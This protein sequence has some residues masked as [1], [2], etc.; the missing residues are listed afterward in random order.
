MEQLSRNPDGPNKVFEDRVINEKIHMDAEKMREISRNAVE[1]NLKNIGVFCL[2]AK[3]DDILMWS[4]YTDGH[5]GFCLAFEKDFYVKKPKKVSYKRKYP[6]IAFTEKKRKEW[7]RKLLL[8]KSKRWKYEE[9]W[10][11]LDR[12][13]GKKPFDETKLF[14]IIFG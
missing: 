10:R 14:G 7:P 11:I 3:C 4:H 2:S 5:Q 8:T 6:L 9:E 12:N 13:P 1:S